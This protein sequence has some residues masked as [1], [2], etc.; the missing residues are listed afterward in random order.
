MITKC[1]DITLIPSGPVCSGFAAQMNLDTH[2]SSINDIYARR[3]YITPDYTQY[4]YQP[5]LDIY[6]LLP[7]TNCG[8]CGFQN[9]MAFAVAVS[10]KK[11]LPNQCPSLRDPINEKAVY[12]IHDNEGNIVSTVE[13]DIESGKRHSV[14]QKLKKYTQTQEKKI[15]KQTKKVTQEKF[16]NNKTGPL[17]PL[18]KREMEVLRL[19]SE[20]CTNIEI[21]KILSISTHT[22]KS[23]VIN[24]FN[25]LGVN[26]RTQASVFALRQQI[27]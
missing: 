22:V 9:C 20:G 7:R 25:K 4:R 24:I 27:I 14:I 15:L 16:K 23:H 26:D 6:R 19:M 13:I 18:S 8:E 5:V 1:S 11:I 21:S 2:I 17:E 10:A 12:P 3:S